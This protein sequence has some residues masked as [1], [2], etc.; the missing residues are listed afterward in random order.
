MK[1]IEKKVKQGLKQLND[2]K[3]FAGLALIVVN[4]ASKHIDIEFTPAQKEIFKHTIS[5]Q[6]LIF[7]IAWVGSRDILV[8]LLITIG[9][10]VVFELLL[11]SKS[12][13]NIL[14]EKLKR[15]EN[16]IDL[17]NDGKIQA[18]ELDKALELIK[19]Y[20]EEN[21]NKSK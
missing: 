20:K 8:S 3:V 2:S 14:P 10:L 12:R 19:R 7:A 15:L 13:F 9:Y 16:V 18:E 6:L 17:N 5:K 21:K 1:N 11:N 4:V